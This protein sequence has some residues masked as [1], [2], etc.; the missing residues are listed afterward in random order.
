MRGRIPHLTLTAVLWVAV[1]SPAFGQKPTDSGLVSR[2]VFERAFVKD[3]TV[4]DI[5]GKNDAAI[6]GPVRL[7]TSPA[8]LILDGE[9]NSLRVADN[10]RSI[11]V[12]EKGITAEAWVIVRTP[13]EWGGIVGVIQDNGGFEKGWLLGIR[14]TNL[15]F[16]LSSQGADDGDGRL[17]YLTAASNIEPGTLY[18]VAGT[19]DGSEMRIYVNANLEN[20]TREQSGKINYPA[21][22]FYD[23]GV[24]H[25]DD[26]FYPLHGDLLEV[27]VYNRALSEDEVRAHF[28]SRQFLIPTPLRFKVPPHIRHIAM[29]EV[30][31]AWQTEEPGPGELE[32]GE[33]SELGQRVEDFSPTAS[34]SVRLRG[35]KPDTDYYFRI[36]SRDAD[37]VR[38]VSELLTFDSS[39]GLSSGVQ[40]EPVSPYREDELTPLYARAAE[41]IIAL[42]GVRKGY[43]LDLACGEGRLAHEIAKRT[44]LKIIGIEED[45]K[46][47]AA[48]RKALDKA[49][50]YGE[51]VTV[52]QGPL[53]KLGYTSRFANLIVSDRAVVSGMLPG[54]SADVFRV[55]KPC[56]GVACI[57]QPEGEIVGGNRLTLSEIDRW[58]RDSPGPKWQIEEEKGTWV[59]I[60]RGPISG[61]GEWTHLYADPENSACSGD[62]LRAPVQV[63][64]FG[65]PGPRNMIDR[66]HRALGPLAKDGRVFVQGNNRILAMDAYNGTLLWDVGIPNSRRVAAAR[67][68]GHVVVTADCVYVAAADKCI[69]LDVETGEVSLAFDIPRFDDAARRYW[70]YVASV[71]DLL[72]GTGEKKGA[73]RTGHS[74]SAIL[75]GTYYDNKPIATSECLFCL[76]RHTGKK[77][78]IYRRKGGSAI[79]NS[80]ITV[81]GGHVYFIESDNPKALT[82]SDGRVTLEV[83]MDKGHAY[84]VKLDQRSGEK[85][86]ERRIEL[87]TIRHVLFLSYANG[88]LVVV[89]SRNDGGH[90][91]YDLHGFDAG[92]GRLVWSNHYIRTDKPT[93]GDHGEQD[94]HPVIIGN[95]VYSRP[96]AYD[97]K[98]GEKKTFKL[99][100]GGRGCGGLSASASYLYGRGGNPRMYPLSGGGRSN[101]A[102]TR[103]SR[104]G[105]WVNIIPAGGLLLIPEGSS[106]CTCGYPLQ[107]SIGLAPREPNTL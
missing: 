106:G 77:L 42:A 12:P 60:R 91:R 105:C 18:H 75:D 21:K 69:G 103:V 97:L 81:G 9:Q 102:L 35:L 58:L 54:S 78:W 26:E 88:M 85:L 24:Y 41:H 27:R 67:D 65:R 100:R 101:I 23:I 52:H 82:D 11:S 90:P 68:C 19:Y 96:Y 84:L 71:G 15:A 63:Q 62:Q 4:K 53:S 47:V 95:T 38:R 5:A 51:R 10:F 59:T 30:A 66:H 36:T 16:S 61:S 44:E 104:P 49:G 73:S 8:G 28:Q 72:F 93:N 43:C 83:L 48:A 22:A 17:T 94:Q 2:W 37:G 86:W 56:G 34:H 3:Q 6:L 76:D 70:G 92:D 31:V 79:V 98:T 89:G 32:Y 64:W 46:K 29:G 87:S 99:D 25:D 107:T 50:I 1:C 57:G 40:P 74:R 7:R 39:S 20:T 45:A 80:A 13:T 14:N 55:L 33:S